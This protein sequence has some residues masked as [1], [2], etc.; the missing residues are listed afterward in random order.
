MDVPVEKREERLKA[1][2]EK[3]NA[4]IARGGRNTEVDVERRLSATA[5]NLRKNGF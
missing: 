1:L 2:R 4:S 5:E 3:V